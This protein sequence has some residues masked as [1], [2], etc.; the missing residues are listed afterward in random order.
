M[1][2]G[3]QASNKKCKIAPFDAYGEYLIKLQV[4]SIYKKTDSIIE[5]NKVPKVNRKKEER[6][7]V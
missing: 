4:R 6:R 5:F 2:N 1:E 3:Y 7:R